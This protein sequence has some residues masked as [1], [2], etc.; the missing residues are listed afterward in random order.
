MKVQTLIDQLLATYSPDTE[1][2]VAYWD[3]EIVN[4]YAGYEQPM[5]NEAW[6]DIVENYENNEWGWQS[7]AADTFADIHDDLK[8][9]KS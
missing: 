8:H 4:S 9:D 7:I 2:A 6:L 5:S 3:K 1:L